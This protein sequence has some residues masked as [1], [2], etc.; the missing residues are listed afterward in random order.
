MVVLLMEVPSTLLA[1]RYQ[2]R[3]LPVSI[4]SPFR[5]SII[6]IE[7]PIS[8]APRPCLRFEGRLLG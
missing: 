6:L 2:Y 1:L 8:V 5:S 3:I 4:L 7:S